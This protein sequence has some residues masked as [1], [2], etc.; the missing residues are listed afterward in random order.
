MIE[1]SIVTA[2]P[3]TTLG[4]TA[5]LR[6]TD[7][8]SGTDIRR[9]GGRHHAQYFG[10]AIT[11]TSTPA[12]TATLRFWFKPKWMNDTAANWTQLALPAMTASGSNTGATTI[13]SP[14]THADTTQ[15]NFATGDQFHY[16]IM[17]ELDYVVATAT[18][19]IADQTLDIFIFV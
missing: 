14:L 4:T 9:E 7:M 18:A 2:T 17:E 6:R 16:L 8:F 3:R 10:I 19:L 1:R 15:S 11:N 5:G 12:A 13:W